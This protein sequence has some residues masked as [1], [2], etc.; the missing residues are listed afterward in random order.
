[1]NYKKQWTILAIS[2]ISLQSFFINTAIADSAAPAHVEAIKGSELSRVTLSE[3]A[4]K[5]IDIKT[6]QVQELASDGVAQ[7]QKT[8]PYASVLYDKHGKTWAYVKTKT[9]TFVRQSI[10]IVR[11]DGDQ[12]ILSNGPAIGT[13]VVTVGVAELFGSE[14]GIGH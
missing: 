6:T 2:V 4:F 7:K 8:I 5:R 14:T 1:M 9:R 13:N 11:I 3:Q 10:G 12:A